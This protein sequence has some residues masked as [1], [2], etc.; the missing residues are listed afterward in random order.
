ML[1]NPLLEQMR[2]KVSQVDKAQID[3][4][5]AL[6]DRIAFLLK[7]NRLSLGE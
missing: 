6:A 4:A 2:E 7:K 3:D 1:K 5:F